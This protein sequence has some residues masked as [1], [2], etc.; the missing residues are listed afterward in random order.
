MKPLLYSLVFATAFLATTSADA[1]KKKKKVETWNLNIKFV[2]GTDTWNT[3]KSALKAFIA[4]QV[5]IAEKIF[6]D[7]PRLKIKYILERKTKL[8]SQPTNR[9]TFAKEKEYRKWMDKYVDNVAK[10]KTDGYITVLVVDQFCFKNKKKKARKT[11]EKYKCPG[12]K[13]W[14]PHWVTP[15]TRKHGIVVVAGN[16]KHTLAHELGHI[17]GLKHTF[18]SYVNVDKKLNCNKDYK[19][20]GKKDGRCRSCKGKRSGS[21][22]KA[23]CSGTANFMDYCFTSKQYINTCQKRRAANQRRKYMTKKGKTNYKK[24]TGNK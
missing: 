24:L 5:Q 4:E 1:G 9:P 14:F 21:G 8:G 7:K 22:D 10:S 3:Q 6:A 16:D 11:G 2:I 19:P 13:A 15:F 12:G 17:F 18:A 20:K 23:T